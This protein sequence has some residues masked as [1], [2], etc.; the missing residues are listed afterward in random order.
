MYLNEGLVLNADTKPFYEVTVSVSDESLVGSSPATVDHKLLVAPV[1]RIPTLASINDLMVEEDSGEAT[2]SLSDISS[3]GRIAQPLRVTATSSN[4]SLIGNPLVTYASP[5]STGSIS[6]SP[7]LNQ[8]GVA[9]ITV[10]VEDGGLDN[11]LTS[12]NDNATYSQS[13][14]VTRYRFERHSDRY[15]HDYRYSS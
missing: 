9:T 14:D 4:L 10:L 1:N 12:T 5:D 6:F 2:V 15:C 13:F 3:G 7:K 11:D 8:F